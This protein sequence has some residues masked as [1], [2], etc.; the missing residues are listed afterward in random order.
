MMKDI[1][2]LTKLIS[3]WYVK[4]NTTLEAASRN[5]VDSGLLCLQIMAISLA[6]R[7]AEE[8]QGLKQ[9]CACHFSS[10]KGHTLLYAPNTTFA[11]NKNCLAA[12]ES[13]T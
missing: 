13:M 10:C 8:I 5:G 11:R 1:A 6:L 7:G 2:L 9:S 4:A 12:C 3:N